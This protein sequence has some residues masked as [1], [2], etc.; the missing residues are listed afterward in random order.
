M[1]VLDAPGAERAVVA[2]VPMGGCVACALIRRWRERVNG[3][4]LINTRAEADTPEGRRRRDVAAHEAREHGAQAIAEAMLPDMLAPGSFERDPALV[5]RVRRVMIRTPVAGIVGAL[6]AMRDRPDSTGLLS[7]L[8]GVPT[9]VI[10]GAEDVIIPRD[11]ARALA[12][13][14][15]GA[16]F[17]LLPGV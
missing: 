14:I 2:G 4:V 5:E 6:S 3:L 13:R 15:P 11:K 17:A 7:E 9:L 8:E 12:D 16:Q 10:A 1:G